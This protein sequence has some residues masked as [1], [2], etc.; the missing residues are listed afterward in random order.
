MKAIGT[1]VAVLLIG[2][3]VAVFVVTRPP[4][5]ELDPEG[6]TWVRNYEAWV[7][8]AERQIRKAEIGLGFSSPAKNARLLEPLRTCSFSFARI[9]RPPEFLGSVEEAVIAAC[10]EAEH[11]VRVND[12]FG[13]ASLA[14]T[15]LHLGEADDRLRLSRRNLQVDLGETDES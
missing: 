6:R 5:R 2:L 3:G 10:G 8:K 15:T 1:I 14:T 9:G 4:N 12:R 7:G 11:A 13:V